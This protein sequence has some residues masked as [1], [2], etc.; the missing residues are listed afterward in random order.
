MGFP[1]FH[2]MMV[3]EDP[4]SCSSGSGGFNHGGLSYKQLEYQHPH[5]LDDHNQTILGP[6]LTHSSG[7]KFSGSNGFPH[8]Q[9]LYRSAQLLLQPQQWLKKG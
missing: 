8:F 2:E 3:F 4:Q 5:F 6:P 1:T 9:I 7:R